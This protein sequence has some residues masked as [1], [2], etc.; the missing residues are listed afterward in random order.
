[1]LECIAKSS[2]K[3]NFWNYG[4][5]RVPQDESKALK[6]TIVVDKGRTGL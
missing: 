3:V 4:P 2:I 1:M 6:E 5:S